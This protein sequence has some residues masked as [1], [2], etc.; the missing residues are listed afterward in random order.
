MT[1]FIITDFSK[2]KS[3]GAGTGKHTEVIGVLSLTI[4]H[5]VSCVICPL[6]CISYI[7]VASVVISDTS[8]VCGGTFGQ[9]IRCRRLR[10][11]LIQQQV[12][13]E[14]TLHHLLLNSLLHRLNERKEF[15]V[16]VRCDT[17]RN[18]RSRNTTCPAQC[19]FRHDKDIRDILSKEAVY[20]HT[21]DQRNNEFLLPS[22]H[23]TEGGGE[24]S[25]WAQCR[26]S[27]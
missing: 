10:K 13:T 19:S 17:R 4:S 27:R 2:T 8:A 9:D 20:Q 12:H 1:P 25:R 24:E 21:R 6:R 23:T 22:P 16:F 3:A 5:S 14:Y 26:R 18:N 7:F 15:L 11:V